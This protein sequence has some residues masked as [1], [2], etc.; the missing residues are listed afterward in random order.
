[1]RRELIAQQGFV[2]YEHGF[3]TQNGTPTPTNSVPITTPNGNLIFDG[4]GNVVPDSSLYFKDG[5]GKTQNLPLLLEGDEIE[6][7][8]RTM[9]AKITH[10]FIL[11]KITSGAASGSYRGSFYISS[12][13]ISFISNHKPKNNG[14]VYSNYC[15]H[16]P[17]AA[18]DGQTYYHYGDC[19]IA[20]NNTSINFWVSQTA[21]TTNAE[22]NSWLA[23]HPM[24]CVYELRTPEI[25]YIDL[26]QK[27][28]NHP[29]MEYGTGIEHRTLTFS[30]GYIDNTGS[31]INDSNYI[32]SDF[33]EGNFRINCNTGYRIVETHLF[34]SSDNLV[35]WKFFENNYH[36][37][38]DYGYGS[39][40]EY[41]IPEGYKMKITVIS[42]SNTTSPYNT[43]DSAITPDTDCIKD[44]SLI[45]TKYFQRESITDP[46][47]K[48]AHKRAEQLTKL[49]WKPVIDKAYK[50]DDYPA[51]LRKDQIQI[52][53]P[54]SE[55]GDQN[56]FVGKQVSFKT[57]LSALK[58]PIS[59]FY[60]ETPYDIANQTR[61]SEYGINYIS[62]EDDTT[63]YY[64]TVCACFADYVYGIDVNYTAR[65]YLYKDWMNAQTITANSDCSNIMPLDCLAVNGHVI[66]VIDVLRDT[67]GN[68]R[69]IETAESRTV[70]C[71]IHYYTPDEFLSLLNS[72]TLRRFSG[73]TV[74]EPEEI[75]TESFEND[76]YTFAGDYAT[77]L[78][79]E[80][81]HI[82]VK[83]NNWSGI[84]VKKNGTVIGT[85]DFT[86][87][88][89]FTIEGQ[90]W[91]DVDISDLFVGEEYA[92]GEH[93][94]YTCVA[95]N[96]NTESNPTHFE[97]L[98]SVSKLYL[99]SSVYNCCFKGD[100]PYAVINGGYNGYPVYSSTSTSSDSLHLANV[101]TTA[102]KNINS[103]GAALSSYWTGMGSCIVNTTG[104]YFR[105]MFK[106]QYGYGT[107]RI[108]KESK[109]DRTPYNLVNGHL[110]SNGAFVSETS[111]GYYSCTNAQTVN[112]NYTYQFSYKDTS[113]ASGYPIRIAEYDSSNN[114]INV[115][116]VG[117]ATNDGLYKTIRYKPTSS[118]VKFRLSCP[119]SFTYKVLFVL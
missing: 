41:E 30:Q 72:Y 101:Y 84:K 113:T 97:V 116:D 77:F 58:N 66:I 70:N 7:N 28:R 38:E 18:G 6:V 105:F 20:S 118:A 74:P 92:E 1:M 89:T 73:I 33:I 93:G 3:C 91:Y 8:F 81:V 48:N 36:S 69:F 12:G 29:L 19:F 78:Q 16:N 119:K 100:N 14:K 35:S 31:L 52:G 90:T 109:A 85:Y 68:V 62:N 22:V 57:F 83:D 117:Y 79:N 26:N 54:Y 80:P 25:E 94:V 9:K 96:G 104:A 64:G 10:R 40:Y 4:N 51:T 65:Y 61:T 114:P 106:G 86:N 56:K 88:R 43:P 42:N 98:Y 71:R 110:D 53:V 108:P 44:Y 82:S 2:A 24:Y 55:V 112:Q 45:I 67:D 107:Y 37:A 47:F 103:Y 21:F 32:T 49:I 17:N 60:T 13:S 59:L 11:Y 23:Q 95:Y 15:L 99:V 5:A 63:L 111:S 27:L 87:A 75:P 102:E 115:I 46:N 76:I 50:R 34:D 39:K